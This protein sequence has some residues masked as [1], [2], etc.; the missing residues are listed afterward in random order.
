[1]QEK[2]MLH[3]KNNLLLFY[4]L[5]FISLVSGGI[6]RA[7]DE[8]DTKLPIPRFVSLKSDNVNIRVGPGTRYSISWVFKRAGYPVE[9]I[10]EFDQWREVRDHEG[11]VGWVHKNMLQGKRNVCITGDVRILKVYPDASSGGIIKAEPG[12]IGQ[13]LE[14]EKSWCR[15]QLGDHKGWLPKNQFWGAYS[16]EE[17]KD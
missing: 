9:I 12:V 15:I 10:Q 1:M 8:E 7:E 17:F 11:S 6:A 4:I 14:C 5:V 3:R 2:A 16:K 13:L